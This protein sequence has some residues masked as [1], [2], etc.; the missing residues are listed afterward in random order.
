MNDFSKFNRIRNSVNRH[1]DFVTN[2]SEVSGNSGFR[3]LHVL[4]LYPDIMN[5]H[6]GR[7]DIMGILQICNL[8]GIP[9][10]IRRLD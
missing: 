6:G 9:V 2:V 8:L 3:C 5:I 1:S 10:E 4:W 7:G